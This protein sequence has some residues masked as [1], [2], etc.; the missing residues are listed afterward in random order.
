MQASDRPSR[1]YAYVLRLWEQQDNDVA[2]DWRCCLEDP[3]TGARRG[4][5][6]LAALMAFLQ[7][8]LLWRPWATHT[9][10]QSTSAD[11]ER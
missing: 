4:F 5:P 2:G 11:Q 8:E 3:H 6:N 9:D 10:D 1:Y 7:D